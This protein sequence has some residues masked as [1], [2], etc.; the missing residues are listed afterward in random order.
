MIPQ[1][2]DL[3]EEL[4]QDVVEGS[5]GLEASWEPH[6]PLYL[7]REDF[8]VDGTPVLVYKLKELI[9]VEVEE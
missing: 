3:E 5:I 1:V 2:H 4:P 9:Y 8:N 6:Q 7:L